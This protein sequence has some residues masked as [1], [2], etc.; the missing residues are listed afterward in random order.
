MNAA[1]VAIIEILKKNVKQKNRIQR[2]CS[3]KMEKQNEGNK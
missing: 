2:R 3:V 1:K